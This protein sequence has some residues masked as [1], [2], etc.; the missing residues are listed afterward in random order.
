MVVT[1]ANGSRERAKEFLFLFLLAE[2]E[3]HT[4]EFVA[5]KKRVLF[6]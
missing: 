2:N 3:D 1:F 4:F 6:R 5:D